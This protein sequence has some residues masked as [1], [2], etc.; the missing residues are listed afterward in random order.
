MTRKYSINLNSDLLHLP[1]FYA[2]PK[3]HKNPYKYRFIAA[4][5][6]CSTKDI[7]ILTFKIL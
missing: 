5:S 6:K 4:A 2:I 3:L 1:Y 7:S